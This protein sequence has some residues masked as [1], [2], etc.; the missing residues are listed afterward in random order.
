MTLE[1]ARLRPPG[2]NSNWRQAGLEGAAYRYKQPEIEHWHPDWW[3]SH[4]TKMHLN[5]ELSRVGEKVVISGSAAQL[6]IVSFE[7]RFELDWRIKHTREAYSAGNVI[8]DQGMLEG[9]FGISDDSGPD[10]EELLRFF[11]GTAGSSEK[12]IRFGDFLNIPNPGTGHDGD[13]N[14]SIE[15]RPTTQRAIKELIEASKV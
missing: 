6:S 7:E 3:H 13:Y 9:A 14:I 10:D 15:L 12:Y 5:D 2:R 11:G 4:G 8:F 1:T